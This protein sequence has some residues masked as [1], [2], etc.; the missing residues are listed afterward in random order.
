MQCNLVVNFHVG[1]NN[2]RHI[3][4]GRGICTHIFKRALHAKQRI[5]FFGLTAIE[6]SMDRL[7]DVKS[8]HQI[9]YQKLIKSFKPALKVPQR[10]GI[11]IRKR[12]SLVTPLVSFSLYCF[13][14]SMLKVPIDGPLAGQIIIRW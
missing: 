1:K 3:P 4:N 6:E 10:L 11:V 12:D 7:Y 2:M 13:P 14:Q 5:N 9:I 8:C